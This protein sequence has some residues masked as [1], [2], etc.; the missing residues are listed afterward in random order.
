MA[1]RPQLN[2]ESLQSLSPSS[3]CCPS[4]PLPGYPRYF[5]EREDAYTF[6]EGALSQTLRLDT[7]NATAGPPAG[8]C[9]RVQQDWETWDV[10]PVPVFSSLHAYDFHHT[11]CYFTLKMVA[12]NSSEMLVHIYQTTWCHIPEDRSLAY[13]LHQSCCHVSSD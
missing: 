13:Q 3:S 5:S 1:Y 7:A 10:T 2:G 11:T 12:L 6:V 4:G 8:R 9:H